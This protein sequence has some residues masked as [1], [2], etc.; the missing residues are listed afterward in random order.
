MN[1]QNIDRPQK[2]ISKKKLWI[3]WSY[4]YETMCF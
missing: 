4:T 3:Y 1:W 2:Q